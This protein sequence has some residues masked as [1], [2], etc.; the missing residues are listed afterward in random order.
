MRKP[1][2]T[3]GTD[4]IFALITTHKNLEAAWQRLHDQ[5]DHA[6]IDAAREYGRR[7][8][9]LIDWRGYTIAASE[10]DTQRK[11]LLFAGE[12]D[13]ATVEREYV[14]A[15]ARYKAEIAA[16]LAWDK[17]AGLQ[18]LS[19]S[20]DQALAV[21]RRCAKRLATTKP[22]TPAGAAALIQHILD[23]GL[24][25][26]EDHWHMTALRSALA[27]LNSMG[28]FTNDSITMMY[29]GVRGALAAD[30]E[31]EAQGEEP[32][33]RVRQIPDWKQH[34]ADLEHEMITRGMKFDLIDWSSGQPELPVYLRP[35]PA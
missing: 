21:A 31:L 9:G 19:K 12:I 4:P 11:Q 7:P 29:E 18:S 3:I 33:F 16:G 25:A 14:R 13:A 22:T 20:L 2:A 8:I 6:E 1:A 23:N 35:Q 34:A 28:A 5:L 32:R 30:D 17:R 15:K 10:I 24:A 26:D 27:A